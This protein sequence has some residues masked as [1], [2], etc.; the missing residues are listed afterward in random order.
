MARNALMSYDHIEE[1]ANFLIYKFKK[2]TL[3]EHADKFLILAPIATGRIE[4]QAYRD[5]N[6]YYNSFSQSGGLRYNV[7]F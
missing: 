5:L 4:F 2:L 7:D 3:G 6:F 1:R